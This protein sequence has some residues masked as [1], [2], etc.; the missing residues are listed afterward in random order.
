MIK[1]LKIDFIKIDGDL[2]RDIG[3][4]EV[5]LSMVESINDMAHLL[6]IKTVAKNVDSELLVDQLKA[7]GI[8]YAQGYYLGELVPFEDIET[9]A[10][11]HHLPETQLN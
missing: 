2:I 5:D 8:D 6:G 11:R 4:D 9:D 7:I 1:N 10:H 3:N